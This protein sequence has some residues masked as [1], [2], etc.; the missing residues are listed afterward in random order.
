M[1]NP[2]RPADRIPQRTQDLTE[3]HAEHEERVANLEAQRRDEFQEEVREEQQE[4]E[5]DEA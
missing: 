3:I 1:G 5:E 2:W 4:D